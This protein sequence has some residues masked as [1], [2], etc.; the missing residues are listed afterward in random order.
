MITS[1]AVLKY[2]YY[3]HTDELK[4][5]S[6]TGLGAAIIQKGKPVAYASRT[7]SDTICSTR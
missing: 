5:T 3:A 2:R 4:D 7:L 6:Q 1:E